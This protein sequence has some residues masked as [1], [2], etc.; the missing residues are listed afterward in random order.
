MPD[1]TTSLILKVHADIQAVDPV[2][3]DRCAG[4][5]NP[6]IGHAFL[7][8]LEESGSVSADSGWL[9]QH[10]VLETEAGQVL[11]CVP[12][13]LK[14]HSYG[15][16]VFDWGWAQAYEE[17]GGHYYPKLQV[18]VPFTPA[19]GP[20]LL[21]NPDVDRDAV[22]DAL[23]SGLQ[24][25][26]DRHQVSGVHVTFPTRS[27]WDRFGAAGWLQR[28]GQQY[29]WE[30]AGYGSFDDF[31]ASL[32]S[33]KRKAIKKERRQVAESGVALEVVTGD[34]LTEA[35]W[36]TFFRFYRNTSD[37]KWGSAYLTREFFSLLGERMGDRV[38]LVVATMDGR[39]VAGA[40]NLIGGDT[41]YGRNWGCDGHFRFL[42]FEAC[43]YRAIDFAIAR[44]LTWVEAGAQGQHKVQRGYLPVHT[45]S[46]HYIR[47]PRFRQAIDDFLAREG[48]MVDWEIQAIAEGSPFRKIGDKSD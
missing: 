35:H 6:F 9:P 22:A 44:G 45:Y 14:T 46:A 29:H 31:L 15:E 16:Y 30:N 12:M 11:G 42:H 32:N 41:L 10:L 21:V 19:T 38:A 23:I 27:E 34:D 36:D 20:R 3:W 13:Y 4:P 26:A 1:D 33:R 47:D 37:R 17:A 5:D 48:R 7:S 43:Y 40:L 2:A 28:T 24:Q 25:V 39:P 8:A 18:S